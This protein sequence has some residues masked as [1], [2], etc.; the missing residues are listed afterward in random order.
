MARFDDQT[1]LIR[2]LFASAG[3]ASAEGEAWAGFLHALRSITQADGA[4]L[5]IDT[6]TPR[7]FGDAPLVDAELRLKLRVERVYDQDGLP[8]FEWRHGFVRAVKVR[9]DQAATVTLWITRGAHLKDFRSVDGQLLSALT[10]FLGQGAEMWL[11]LLETR[12]EAARTD[13]VAMQSGLGWVQF[14]RSAIIT[15]YSSMVGAWAEERGMRLSERR[16]FELAD[17][18]AAQAFRAAFQQV[19]A[20]A[21]RDVAVIGVEP[22]TELVLTQG[23]DQTILGTLRVAQPAADVAPETVAAHFGISKSEARLAMQLCDGASIKEAAMALGWTEE[24][25]RTTSKA[26]F[27]RLGISG[28]PA[29]V[30]RMMGS[31]L[32]LG[33]LD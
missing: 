10:P 15:S 20:G 2:A 33:R 16:R 1:E 17:D 23:E 21:A 19:L 5:V 6:E 25:A 4:A 11:R 29:L 30:R 12:R 22:L 14:E 26:I 18:G 31:G 8:N 3:D 13:A 32:W 28:Q 24:T 27:A 9:I 7:L